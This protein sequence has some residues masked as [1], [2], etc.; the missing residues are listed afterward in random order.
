VITKNYFFPESFK[1]AEKIYFLKI[2]NSSSALSSE[3]VENYFEIDDL[4][5]V[6]TFQ[7]VKFIE[8][9]FHHL[10]QLVKFFSTC[11]ELRF[12]ALKGLSCHLEV[13]C[14]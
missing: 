3:A 13:V 8:L 1:L 2:K 11:N 12:Y 14:A 7:L 10:H 5:T 9:P 4:T 6:W